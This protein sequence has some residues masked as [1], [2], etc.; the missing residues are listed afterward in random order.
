L[1]HRISGTVYTFWIINR[2]VSRLLEFGLTMEQ[3]DFELKREAERDYGVNGMNWHTVFPG[4]MTWC[5]GK[6]V[7]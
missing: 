5:W 3:I 1:I 7:K 2:I 4:L 6:V